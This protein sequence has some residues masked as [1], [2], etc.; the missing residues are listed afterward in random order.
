MLGNLVVQQVKN[1]HIQS[2]GRLYF[3]K[4]KRNA[5]NPIL[6]MSINGAAT[7]LGLASSVI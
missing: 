4:S 1:R 3:K 6:K 5:P 2:I 7:I